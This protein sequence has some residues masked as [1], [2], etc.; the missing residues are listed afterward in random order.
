MRLIPVRLWALALL[1][2]LLQVL[3]FPLAGPVPL[4]RTAFCWI[5]LLPLFAALAGKNKSGNTLTLMQGAL[6]GYACGFVWYLGNCYW[7]YQTMHLYGALPEPIA[8]GILILFCF[9]LG[10]YHALFAAMLT[11]IR[12]SAVGW[13]GALLLAPFAWVA[14]ELAR[15]RITGLPWDLLGIAQVDNPLLIRLAP[16]TGAYGLS[17]VIAAVNA[18]WLVRISL[19]ERRHTK[20][21]LSIVGVVVIVLYVLTLHRVEAPRR[22]PVEAHATLVQENLEVGAAMTGPAPTAGDLV[23]SFS[24]LSRFPANRIL[25]GIPELPGTPDILFEARKGPAETDLIV[26]PES[27]AP[28]EDRDPAF[29]AGMS[30]LARA[31]GTPVI[32]GNIGLDANPAA[33][34][35]LDLHNRASFVAPDGTFIGHYD[36][37]HLV[38]FG[39]YTPFK[40]LFFFAGSLLEEVGT[41]DPGV[42]RTVFSTGG[43]RYGT[44]ICYESIFGDE[45]RRFTTQGADVLVNV[46][47]DGWYGDTSAPWQHL[48]MVRMRAIENHRWVLRATNTGVTAAID[49][50]GHVTAAAPRHIRTAIRVGFGYEHDLT[51]Y[52]AH[53]DIFAYA[54]ALVTMLAVGYSLSAGRSKPTTHMQ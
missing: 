33:P 22:S 9:Y 8:A 39:E 50:W 1:S 32:V 51:F 49:P 3:P 38:P 34:H 18:L 10:L 48:N 23:Q 35:G 15:A 30:A 5:A 13:Q 11:A 36:K 21:I 27:P 45:V 44:F 40:R 17:F 29:R 43:H 28:F 24:Q 19:R 14:V 37:I 7:I 26:W 2:G 54:C 25:A 16:I 42:E 4:W 53:G 12:R 31:T 20:L 47:N 46:S 6:L 52:A 41:F